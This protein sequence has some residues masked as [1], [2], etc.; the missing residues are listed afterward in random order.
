MANGISTERRG[1]FSSLRI[2]Y[3]IIEQKWRFLL[4]ARIALGVFGGTLFSALFSAYQ[5]LIPIDGE[6]RGFAYLGL[7]FIPVIA[8]ASLWA[9]SLVEHRLYSFYR[10]CVRRGETVELELGI[11]DDIYGRLRT[12][13]RPFGGVTSCIDAYVVI[14]LASAIWLSVLVHT[15]LTK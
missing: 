3:G 9:I 5:A 14:A 12:L 13:P 15:L 7:G 2:E 11:T 8:V 6:M 10:A 4:G 1:L